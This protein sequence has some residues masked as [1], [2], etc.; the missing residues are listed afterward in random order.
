MI[1]EKNLKQN[2]SWHCPFKQPESILLML[3]ILLEARRKP[4]HFKTYLWA[5]DLYGPVRNAFDAGKSITRASGK[6][7]GPV[8]WHRAVRRVPFEISRAQ[9]PPALNSDQCSKLKSQNL[10]EINRKL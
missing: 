4:M 6:G 10:L 9:T 7:L 2:V 3:Y 8:K 1:H 5:Y